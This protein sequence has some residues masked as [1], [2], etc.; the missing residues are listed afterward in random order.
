LAVRTFLGLGLE[1][2][3]PDHSTISR[4]RRLIDVETH[5]AVFTW[6]Q[7]R[8]VDAKLLRGQ[9][10]G[11]DATTLEANAAMRSIVRRDT[12]EG[13]VDFLTKLA[14]AS[15]I[16]TP[17]REA[18]ARF[19]RKRKKKGANKEWTSPSDPDARITKMKDGRTHLAAKAEHVVD[20]DTGAIV[21]VTL[22]GA[23]VGDTTSVHETLIAAAEQIEAVRPR[24]NPGTQIEE[25]IS[26]PWRFGRT[27][28]NQTADD[29]SG[30]RLPRPRPPCTATGAAFEGAGASAS[31]D[32]AANCSSGR[33]RTCTRRGACGGRTCGA[34]RT[35]SS[36]WSSTRPVSISGS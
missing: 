15:G 21:T 19:D 16:K 25:L 24:D 14:E 2:A 4:T 28:R 5:R 10:V 11:I 7:E 36:D 6:V 27:C 8:L 35:S 32:G 22:Q 33:T 30:R 23:D 29:A 12:G 3:S 18:L 31:C 34:I 13:Y 17:T 20:L 1:E 26:A 9:T